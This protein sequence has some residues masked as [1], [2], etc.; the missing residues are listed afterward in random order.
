MDKKSFRI[1]STPGGSDKVLN[2]KLDQ[3]FDYLDILSLKISKENFYKNFTSDYGVVVGRVIAND[4]LG[5]PNANISLF[6]PLEENDETDPKISYLYPF[7]K[8]TDKTSNFTEYNL[9]IPKEGYRVGT[10]PSKQQF[11]DDDTYIE[12]Y[13][14]YYK[15]TTKTNT[16]G[17]YMLFG[18]PTGYQTLHMDMDLSDIGRFSY[19]PNDM[20]GSGLPENLLKKAKDDSF[21]FNTSNELSSLPQIISQNTSIDIKPLWGDKVEFEIGITRFDF[22][23]Q[24]TSSPVATFVV[25]IGIDR[26]SNTVKKTAGFINNYISLM[27]YNGRGDGVTGSSDDDG[28]LPGR[29]SNMSAFV[30]SDGVNNAGEP[31]FKVTKWESDSSN[32]FETTSVKVN[33]NASTSNNG[34]MILYLPCDQDRVITDESGTIIP[35]DD[36][37]KGLGTTGRYTIEVILDEGSEP[38]LG[39]YWSFKI[40]HENNPDTVNNREPFTYSAKGIYSVA[41]KFRNNKGNEF[42]YAIRPA[43]RAQEARTLSEYPSRKMNAEDWINCFLYFGRVGNK[44]NTSTQQNTPRNLLYEADGRR[45][46]DVQTRVID[47]TDYFDALS[48]HT[49]Y[50]NLVGKND[51]NYIAK[52]VTYQ[53]KNTI[54]RTSNSQ[55]ALPLTTQTDKDARKLFLLG[56]RNGKN[57]FKEFKKLIKR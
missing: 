7:K 19:T 5:I 26:F 17:D 42:P 34:I 49:T 6:I 37:T 12:I 55:Q 24:L 45:Y 1:Q 53:D 31:Y 54:S 28:N 15:F 32:G 36:E 20:L 48:E 10:F 14:K 51:G 3:S 33:K 39:E 52:S 8:V 4:G 35:T 25:N 30:S 40:E 22:K 56:L 50:Y 38:D 13:E 46:Y 47:I 43:H 29:I 27:N 2:I 11:L 21:E 9:L 57:N 23:V 41:M 44:E 18:V 16:S